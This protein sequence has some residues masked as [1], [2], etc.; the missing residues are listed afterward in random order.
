MLEDI[1]WAFRQNT[2]S[3][4]S[5]FILVII[6]MDSGMDHGSPTQPDRLA[7]LTGIE[8]GLVY[9]HLHILQREGF[10]YSD[11]LRSP[12]G[13]DRFGFYMNFDNDPAW[14]EQLKLENS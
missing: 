9:V 1:E 14:A 4:E 8:L 10:L 5:K 2:G 11:R 7:K 3:V 12:E 13:A 6:A